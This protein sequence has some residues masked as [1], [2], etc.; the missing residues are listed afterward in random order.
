MASYYDYHLV[1]AK[2]D[3]Y[4][5]FRF[6]YRSWENLRLLQLTPAEKPDFL[7]ASP[8]K[9]LHSQVAAH[10]STDTRDSAHRSPESGSTPCIYEEPKFDDYR[11]DNT[12]KSWLTENMGFDFATT[13]SRDQTR[14]PTAAW[15]QHDSESGVVSANLPAALA[16]L[17][18]DSLVGAR[19]ASIHKGRPLPQ[20]PISHKSTA[21]PVDNKG[22]QGTPEVE[23]RDGGVFNEGEEFHIQRTRGL[24]AVS[25][26]SAASKVS[27]AKSLQAYADG[28]DGLFV[29]TMEFG[30]ATK[31]ETVFHGKASGK[32][33]PKSNQNKCSV[34]PSD[35]I[36]PGARSCTSVEVC[37]P[38]SEYLTPSPTKKKSKS[39]ILFVAPFTDSLRKR[40]VA[41][42]P[43]SGTYAATL[44]R[45]FS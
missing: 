5:S 2:D 22:G 7:C 1:D 30:S 3:P 10:G 34:A 23:K 38:T 33:S 6:H 27:I 26:G 25:K 45:R 8:S 19:L 44:P 36:S 20:L 31:L 32:P 17:E 37:G 15:L 28:E 43:L 13:S 9:S 29:D 35:S 40:E 24:S 18:S 12:R 4:A 16:T 21:D 42:V 14:E 39:K 41:P 11:R